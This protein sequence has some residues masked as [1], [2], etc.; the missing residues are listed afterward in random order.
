M[1][2]KK[3]SSIPVPFALPQVTGQSGS[4]ACY[5]MN[6]REREVARNC[7]HTAKRPWRVRA[8]VRENEFMLC[9]REARV[10][11]G[12]WPGERRQ[13]EREIGAEMTGT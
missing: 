1:P 2:F 4:L 9:A 7:E 11:G 8:G 10:S 3:P 12:D 6:S 5:N 13:Q